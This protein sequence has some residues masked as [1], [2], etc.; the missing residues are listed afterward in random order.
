MG[1]AGIETIPHAGRGKDPS[2]GRFAGLFSNPSQFFLT[3][4]TSGFSLNWS[5]DNLRIFER[6]EV[7]IPVYYEFVSFREDHLDE[8]LHPSET[9]A[10]NLSLAGVGVT[11]FPNLDHHNIQKLLK[12]EKKV[13]LGLQ[14]YPDMPPVIVFARMVWNEETKSQKYPTSS[15]CAFIDINPE[16]YYLIKEFLA[17]LPSP[18]CT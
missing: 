14:L 11:G 7:D 9:R 10:V 17:S 16:S 15:G 2:G 6:R 13:R 1:S 18:Q 5:M 3:A 4:Y 8:L 12:G